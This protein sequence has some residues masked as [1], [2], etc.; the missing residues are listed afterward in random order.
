MGISGGG[1][2]GLLPRRSGSGV[3]LALRA[4]C[5]QGLQTDDGLTQHQFRCSLWNSGVE[6]TQEENLSPD[7]NAKTGKGSKREE[8][9]G[10]NR[11]IFAA[12]RCS[13]L[14]EVIH[15]AGGNELGPFR[16]SSTMPMNYRP[17]WY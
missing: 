6:A 12:Q 7:P 9:F 5:A 15:F 8:V 17:I 13:W 16:I 10:W 2:G 11:P 4:P 14:G 3:A 1:E